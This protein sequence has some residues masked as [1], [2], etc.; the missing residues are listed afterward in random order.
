MEKSFLIQRM[1]DKLFYNLK[2]GWSERIVGLTS[3]FP[4]KESALSYLENIYLINEDYTIIEV[5]YSFKSR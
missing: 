2:G 4:S 5:Y 3:S 1:S